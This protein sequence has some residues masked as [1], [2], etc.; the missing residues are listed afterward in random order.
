MAVAEVVLT[1]GT[2][3][4][5]R[6]DYPKKLPLDEVRSILAKAS[7]DSDKGSL[8]G[9]LADSPEDWVTIPSRSIKYITLWGGAA[10]EV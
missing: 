3:I 4:R 7:N 9:P 5:I 1:D 6:T 10:D 8:R 2:R